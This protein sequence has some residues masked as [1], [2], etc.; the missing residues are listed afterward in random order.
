MKVR[1]GELIDSAARSTGVDYTLLACIVY[2]ES[3]GNVWA[4]RY[5]PAFYNDR[6]EPLSREMLSG[7]V[8]PHLPNLAT[9]KRNRAFSFGLCQILGET[10]RSKLH[11][12]HDNLS[13]LFDPELNLLMGGT[14]LALLDADYKWIPDPKEREKAVVKR[15]NGKGEAARV[16]QEGVFRIRDSEI[17]QTILDITV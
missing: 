5:E 16:Y 8:P 14:L 1:L 15:Y 3:E 10:A 17:W 4:H 9:E 7:Y 11:F 6:I 2:K 13:E 12:N